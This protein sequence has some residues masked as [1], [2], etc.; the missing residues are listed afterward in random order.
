M[1]P[2]FVLWPCVTNYMAFGSR[3][4]YP[5]YLKEMCSCEIIVKNVLKLFLFISR[6]LLS[7]R[8]QFNKWTWPR[9]LLHHVS[10]NSYFHGSARLVLRS[11]WY[12]HQRQSLRIECRSFRES[13]DSRSC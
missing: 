3:I 2:Y 4:F 8:L 5:A 10:E 7:K 13:F 1:R 9:K 11:Y 6:A 12:H